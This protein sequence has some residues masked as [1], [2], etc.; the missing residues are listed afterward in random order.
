MTSKERVG[1]K[2]LKRIKNDYVFR[3]FIF[4]ALSFLITMLFTAYNVFLYIA[5]KAVWNIGIAVY[6]ALL[7]SIR[8]YVICSGCVNGVAEE[9]GYLFHYS[10]DCSCGIYDVQNCYINNKYYQNEKGTSF[11]PEN[12]AYR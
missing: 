1:I 7:L 11:K 10:R 6:Y 4:S 3:A 8:A 5:Y 2:L 12:I 9:N